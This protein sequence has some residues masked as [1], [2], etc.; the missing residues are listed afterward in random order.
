MTSSDVMT[1]TLCRHWRHYIFITC[2]SHLSTRSFSP[3]KSSTT[4]PKSFQLRKKLTLGVTDQKKTS[5]LFSTF[6]KCIRPGNSVPKSSMSVCLTAMV[7]LST[8]FQNLMTEN[9]STKNWHLFR[10]SIRPRLT[11]FSS[12]FDSLSPFSFA[13]SGLTSTMTSTATLVLLL[14]ALLFQPT[15]KTMSSRRRHQTSRCWQTCCVQT[16]CYNQGFLFNFWHSWKIRQ[17]VFFEQGLVCC[18]S[19]TS[20]SEAFCLA[21]SI[22]EKFICFTLDSTWHDA[23][24]SKILVILLAARPCCQRPENATTNAFVNCVTCLSLILTMLWLSLCFW[25]ARLMDAKTSRHGWCRR[26][27]PQDDDSEWFVSIYEYLQKFF[28]TTTWTTWVARLDGGIGGK[29]GMGVE[30]GIALG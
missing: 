8:S 21:S 30:L 20:E 29:E 7:F 5:I 1:L 17:V 11:G 26:L 12:S 16:F 10:L 2:L 4:P 6:L 14:T 24:P 28:S 27:A 23:W 9:W 15:T 19:P 22:G 13:F 18:S 3:G 25:H